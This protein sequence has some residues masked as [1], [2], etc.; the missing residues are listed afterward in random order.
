MWKSLDSSCCTFAAW[1][2]S[3][4]Q[5]SAGSHVSLTRVRFQSECWFDEVDEWRN[6]KRV[7]YLQQLICPF[8]IWSNI[9]SG[10]TVKKGH[11]NFVLEQLYKYS[12]MRRPLFWMGAI[13][14]NVELSWIKCEMQWPQGEGPRQWSIVYNVCLFGRELHNPTGHERPKDKQL[15]P[16]V[17]GEW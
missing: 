1:M 14:I 17:F 12:V 5:K 15:F 10:I 8:S 3:F 11:K 4:T 13:W 9:C 6:K 2:C 16:A 7:H